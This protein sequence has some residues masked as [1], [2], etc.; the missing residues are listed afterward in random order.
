VS[1]KTNV[2]AELELAQNVAG[3]DSTLGEKTRDAWLDRQSL[4]PVKR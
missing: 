2:G 1:E 3:D 4:H